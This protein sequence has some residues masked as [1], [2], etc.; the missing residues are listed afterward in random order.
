MNYRY[1]TP[2]TLFE[3]VPEVGQVLRG[4]GQ[5]LGQG[6]TCQEGG[7]VGPAPGNVPHG[8]ASTTQHLPS[9][10]SISTDDD[11]LMFYEGKLHNSLPAI[12]LQLVPPYQQRESQVPHPLYTSPVSPGGE[13]EGAE[14]VLCQ[15]VVCHLSPVLGN[16]SIITCHL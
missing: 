12:G 2:G 8:V 4:G 1:C 5:L 11:K 10:D 16:L 15:S 14:P 13:T 6:D 7:L 9:Q 3:V